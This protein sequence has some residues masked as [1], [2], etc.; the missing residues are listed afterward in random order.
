MSVVKFTP[1]GMD[2][3]QRKTQGITVTVWVSSRDDA[4]EYDSICTK[5]GTHLSNYHTGR[6]IQRGAESTQRQTTV[7]IQLRGNKT[8]KE[9][10]YAPRRKLT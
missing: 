6:A 9:V 7:S 3:N 10:R 1:S 4:T 2:C 5:K 8:C